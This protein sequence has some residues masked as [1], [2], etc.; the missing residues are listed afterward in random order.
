MPIVNGKKYSY[1]KKGKAAAK[2]AAKKKG[3]S[4]QYESNVSFYIQLAAMLVE[5]SKPDFLDMDDDGNKTE[6]MKKAIRDKENRKPRSTKK[7]A[8]KTSK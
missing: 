5:G 8:K 3:V 6:T 2:K 1:N 7:K 4:L